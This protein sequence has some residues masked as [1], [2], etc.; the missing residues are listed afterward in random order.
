M[1]TGGDAEAAADVEQREAVARNEDDLFG[2]RQ[3]EH[4]E[5]EADDESDDDGG[6]T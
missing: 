5:D 2:K 3:D 4:P 6:E 1:S